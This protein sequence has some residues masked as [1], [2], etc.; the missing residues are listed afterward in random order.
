MSA[1]PAPLTLPPGYT[2]R[3]PAA[4]DVPAI[5][6]LIAAADRHDYGM[7]DEYSAQDILDQGTQRESDAWLVR[8]PAGRAAGYAFVTAG[9]YG[10]VEAEIY[11]HPH[12]HGRGIGTALVGLSEARA[13][14]YG[15]GVPAE[16]QVLLIVH[17]SARNEAAAR[18]LTRLGFA[19]VRHT[20]RMEIELH[21]APPAPAWPPGITVRTAEP[22]RDEPAVFAAID[23][24]FRDV[25][26]RAP[27]V[28]EAWREGWARRPGFDPGLWWLAW[29]GESLAGVLLA[30][31]EGSLG[32]VGQLG[33]RRPWRRRG[34][35]LALLRTA[36]A[37]F[38]RR[39][40][41]Q[42][43]LAVDARSL[44]GATRLYERAGMR[45]A[46]HFARYHKVLRA[47]IDPAARP[48]GD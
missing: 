43:Y 38:Y 21:E 48:D 24:S 34:L 15:A 5:I 7:A 41:R 16:L 4:E 42:V 44:T 27:M 35:G 6:E 25:W 9:P 14:E 20:W 8:T 23:E 11:V 45:V 46:L 29:E 3:P 19:L 28:F 37:E 22:G 47:G 10:Q 2:V 36:F 12:D 13:R 17:A 26:G 31:Q 32:H 40:T 33:V 30:E 1:I 39:G 18:L